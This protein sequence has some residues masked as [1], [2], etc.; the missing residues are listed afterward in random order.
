M[1]TPLTRTG[2]TKVDVTELADVEATVNDNL[3]IINALMTMG[4]VGLDASKPAAGTANSVYLSTDVGTDGTLY[5][6]NGSA[7]K[8]VNPKDAAGAIAALR[9]LGTGSTQ[10]AAG[11][12]ARF[13]STDQKAALAGTGTPG[14]GNKYVT[15]DDARMTDQRVPTAGSVTAAKMGKVAVAGLHTSHAFKDTDGN[16]IV[17]ASGTSDV[18]SEPTT[19]IDVT[20]ATSRLTARRTGY[21][22]VDVSGIMSSTVANH[23]YVTMLATNGTVDAGT[24]LHYAWC[25]TTSAYLPVTFSK[26]VHLTAGDYLQLATTTD[27]TTNGT[28]T[29]Y[30]F[31]IEYLGTD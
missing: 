24:I 11:N 20:A 7:W 27:A 2:M 3:D 31:Q 1:S 10:A 19:G 21:Y 15:N 17:A 18:A 30:H 25:T 22:R 14:A 4:A 9:T 13:P 28:F 6:D 23:F 5:I 16:K 29:V 12:D 26:V 8:A